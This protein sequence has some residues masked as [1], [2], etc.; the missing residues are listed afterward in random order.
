[1][2]TL[3][4]S[5]AI[6]VPGDKSISH[7]ALMMAALADGTSTLSGLLESEDVESTAR[8]LR[9]LGAKIPALADRVRITGIGLRGMKSHGT[10]LDCGNSGTTTR[11]VAGIVAGQSIR[12]RF[13]GDA[14]LSARP[15]KRIADP[16]VA[17]G[18]T[19]TFSGDDGLPMT[20]TGAQ[21]D[22]ID[23]D[24]R[25]ASAQV[26]SAILFAALTSGV[27]VTVRETARS[28]DH[29]ERML[30]ALGAGVRVDEMTVH[31]TPASSIRPLDITVPADPSSS[32][33]FIALATLATEGE[34]SLPN[35]CVNPTRGGFIAALTR[36]GG[37]IELENPSSEAGEDTATLRIRPAEL[38]PLQIVAADVPSMID[39]LPMLACVAAGAGVSLHIHGASELRHKESDRIKAIVENLTRIGASAEETADG[40]V[41]LEGRKKLSG[42]VITRGDHRIAMA[43]GVLSK[44]PGNDIRIDDRDC[45]A[46]SYPGFWRDLDRAVA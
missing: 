22:P 17:M 40:L 24:T 3:S 44:I 10:D 9:A 36:M 6:Q 37:A 2:A 18:A 8:V 12:A 20:V 35:V 31:F 14:S 43:F 16:L 46:V 5:G 19:F 34:L 28:R 33:F 25:G 7:R 23:W 15:M 26:K 41:V 11:L 38:K 32:A 45:V 29:T 27:E 13:T 4:V 1:L 21:L 42:E 39:E 30:A